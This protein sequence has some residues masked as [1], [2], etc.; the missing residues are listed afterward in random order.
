MTTLLG[1]VRVYAGILSFCWVGG[2]FSMLWIC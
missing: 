1:T 2:W